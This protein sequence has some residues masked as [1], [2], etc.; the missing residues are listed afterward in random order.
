MDV[1]TFLVSTFCPSDCDGLVTQALLMADF[2]SAVDVCLHS[3]KMAEAI[4]LAIAGGPELLE[5]TQKA[6]F[7]KNKGSLSRVCNIV[8]WHISLLLKYIYHFQ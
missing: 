1:E 5:R 4:I 7:Q 2:Q 3:N 8:E 6:F